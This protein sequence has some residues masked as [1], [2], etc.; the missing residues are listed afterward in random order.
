LA[1]ALTVSTNKRPATLSNALNLEPIVA[2][3]CK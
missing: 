3:L 1:K 2:I